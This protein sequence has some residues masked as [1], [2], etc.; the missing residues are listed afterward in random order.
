MRVFVGFVFLLSLT[1]NLFAGQVDW[2][3]R[4][5]TK[6]IEFVPWLEVE[7]FV[8]NSDCEFNLLRPDH[9][10]PSANLFF[11]FLNQEVYLKLISSQTDKCLMTFHSGDLIKQGRF[12]FLG[13]LE[14]RYV[15]SYKLKPLELCG[16]DPLVGYY[17]DFVYSDNRKK[18]FTVEIRYYRYKDKSGRIFFTS[19]SGL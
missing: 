14:H 10:C 15:V 16:K 8:K 18:L 9:F 19:P 11:K 1:G 3:A 7:G 17:L 6:N 4:A 2:S 5:Q 12:Y 13:A